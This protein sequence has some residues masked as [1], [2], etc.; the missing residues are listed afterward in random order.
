MSTTSPDTQARI[1]E[2]KNA[3]VRVRRVAGVGALLGLILLLRFCASAFAGHLTWGRA[4]ASGIVQFLL[5]WF[6]SFSVQDRRWW[7]WWSLLVLIILHIRGTL[8]HTMRLVR[9]TI[10]RGLAAH[11]REIAFDVVG[12]AQFIVNGLLL[13]LLFSKDVR[14]YVRSL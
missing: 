7:G 10:E 9:I 4:I 11:G 8:G 3:P 14:D 5:F 12:V 2:L 6:L 13:W 1:A